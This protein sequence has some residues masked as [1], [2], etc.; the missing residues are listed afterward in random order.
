ME[1]TKDT[2]APDAGYPTD[3]AC[4][5]GKTEGIP[6]DPRVERTRRAIWSALLTL[7]LEQ[8]F[9][10]VTVAQIA[11]RAG[12]NRSTF[13]AHFPDKHAVV[14]E[15]LARLL[16]DLRARQETPTPESYARFDPATPHPNALRWFAHVEAYE[17]FYAAV[18][19]TGELASFEGEVAG[20]IS[21]WALS[22]LREWPGDLQPKAPISAL[23]AASTAMNLGLVRWWLSQSPRPGWEEMAVLQQRLQACGV[24]PLLGLRQD[25]PSPQAF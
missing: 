10:A 4:L 12:I 6:I 9:H 7:S 5:S 19:V 1:R 23:I 8:G 20:L 13:Y 14:R 24:L 22:R 16:R 21:H 2:R 11:R 18:L 25:T 15:E 17:E 3:P